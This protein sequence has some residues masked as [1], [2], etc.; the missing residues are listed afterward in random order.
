MFCIGEASSVG[1]LRVLAKADS[2]PCVKTVVSTL[3]R[4]EMLH[5]KF[6]WALA[7]LV[8]PRL[9]DDEAEWLA[10]DLAWS[11]AHYDRIHSPIATDEVP[12]AAPELGVGVR[13]ETGK[14]FNDRIEKLILPGL[15]KLGVPAYEA[16]ALREHAKPA[17]PQ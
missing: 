1:V 4:D 6:G 15:A 12:R 2:H 16:W 7:R 3:L 14:A 5:D 10:A 8:L 13:A 9:T 11:F 17:G